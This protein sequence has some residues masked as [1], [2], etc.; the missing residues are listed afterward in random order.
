MAMKSK[1]IVTSAKKLALLLIA[2]SVLGLSTLAEPLRKQM[3]FTVSADYRLGM[4][5]Y[6]LPAGNY[7]LYQINDNN[8]NL[9]ALYQDDM[10]TSPIAMVQTTR[11]EP[12]ARWP[13]NTRMHYEIDDA[14]PTITG[15]QVAGM[16]GWEIIAV[17][18]KGRGMRVL[19]RVR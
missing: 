13:Q 3:N 12:S 19:T 5:G 14:I 18:P 8:S 1:T 7:I 6:V 9:F 2:M 10:T 4:K 11:I 16:N 17:V 15:W